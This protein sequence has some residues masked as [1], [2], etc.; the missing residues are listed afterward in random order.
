MSLFEPILTDP[1]PAR[2]TSRHDPRFICSSGIYPP[3]F[4]SLY[5]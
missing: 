1:A 2:K 3:I 4:L 5:S